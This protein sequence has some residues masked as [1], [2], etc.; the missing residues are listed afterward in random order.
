MAKPSGTVARVASGVVGLAAVSVVSTLSQI[1]VVPL[2]LRWWG[3]ERY[4]EWVTLTALVTFLTLTDLGVQTYVVNRMAAN[5]A[6]GRLDD[7]QR[8]LDD[9]LGFQAPLA[10]A[11]LVMIAIGAFALPVQRWMGLGQITGTQTGA[12]LVLL[13][14]E[15]ILGVPTGVA[16]GI[17]RASGRLARGAWFDVA[18]RSVALLATLIVIVGGTGVVG[19]AVVRAAMAILAAAVLFWDLGRTMPGLSFR[20]SHGRPAPGVRLAAAG[21]PFLLLP[22]AEFAASQGSLLI[23]QRSGSGLAVAEFATH[24]TIA[25]ATMMA[26]S[27]FTAA[28]WPELTRMDALADTPG[29]RRA[30]LVLTRMNVMAVGGT[31]A[32]VFAIAPVVYPAWTGHRLH[33]DNGVLF[34][35][36]LRA[37]MWSVWGAAG[38]VLAATNRKRW[39]V[40]SHALGAMTVVSLSS[41]LIPRWGALG[42]AIALVVGEALSQGWALPLSAC[43]I[44]GTAPGDWTRNVAWAATG[45][46]V[47]PLLIALGIRSV[48]GDGVASVL[49]S[50]CAAVGATM[51]GSWAAAGAEVRNALVVAAKRRLRWGGHRS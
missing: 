50:G 19:V 41:V 1:V 30:F 3:P 25:N 18:R 33:L 24:R 26:A 9:A 31:F 36:G 49:A 14:I 51:A 17:Y 22:L 42:A 35:L 43:R 34:L 20:L 38:T 11:L 44:S 46:G 7:V 21:L 27:F 37:V 10:G 47:V 13:A 45:A 2:A 40:V 15:P 28:V 6:R 12:V 8:D 23:L 48:T 16:A 5:H 29:V 4:G 39:L 32:V